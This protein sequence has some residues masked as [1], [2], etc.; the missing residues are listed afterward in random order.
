[1]RLKILVDTNVLISAMIY[2]QSKPSSVLYY[3]AEYHD[4]VLT[5]Y[6]IVELRRIAETK[7]ARAQADVDI[8]LAEF[9]FELLLAF[10]SPQE[11]IRDPD[12]QPILNVAIA[13][14]V[15]II[16]TGDKDFLS[17]DLTR[18]RSMTVAQFITFSKMI[19][20]L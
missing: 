7:F 2:P 3:I 9:S 17:L 14:D 19:P 4:L 1:M 15:D 13:A 6:N 11:S 18:P 20:L 5:D 12:D 10:S 8:F 16:L